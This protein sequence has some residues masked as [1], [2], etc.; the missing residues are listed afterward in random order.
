VEAE[1]AAYWLAWVRFGQL[2]AVFLVAI[3]VVAEFAGEYLSRKLEAPI[4]A[5]RE[6]RLATLAAEN[7]SAR[8]AIADANAR[9]A[10]ASQKAAEAQ[11][12]LERFKAP[13]TLRPERQHAVTAAVKPFAGQ[14]YQTAIS[15]GAD[16]GIVFWE[17]LYKALEQAGWEYIPATSFT[18]GNPPAG[19]PIAAIPGLEIRF[20]PAKDQE[21]APAA[22][23]LGNALHA[24][25]MV[26]AVN[27]NRQ[28]S[29]NEAERNIL[30]IFIGARV[31][32]P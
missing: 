12:A 24:D 1:T 16:D 15:Q 32:P 7:T 10:E 29:P 17:S 9:T 21:L 2:I 31:P 8:A 30:Q 19:I 6:E 14:R 4:E 25:G 3:G 18:V 23:A 22:L 20:D 26:V 13:R 28:T 27:R 5:A 11:L